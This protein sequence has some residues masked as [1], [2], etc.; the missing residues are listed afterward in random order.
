LATAMVRSSAKLP[1]E[2]SWLPQRGIASGIRQGRKD[3][4]K[5]GQEES[6]GCTVPEGQRKL[7]PTAGRRGGIATTASE[8]ARQLELFSE[9]AEVPKGNNAQADRGLP[10]SVRSDEPKSGNA[11]QEV[12]PPMTMEEVANEGN[13][14]RAFV[15]VKGNRG[16]PGPDRQS[17]EAVAAGMET[18]IPA[19][20]KSLLEGTYRAGDI[21]RVWIPKGGGGQ[22]GLGIPNVV[23]RLVQQA[24]QQVL[25]PHYEPT[26][27]ESSHGFRPGRSCHTA[28]EEARKHLEEGNEWV[29]DLD[30]EKFFD[31]VQHDRLM[32]RLGQ[33]VEDTRVLRL[34][35][36]MLRARVVMPDGVVVMTEEGVPQGG[37]LSPL[38]S[39]IVLD[40][41]DRELARRG[42][43]FTRYADDCN[44]Y[45][46]SERAGQ[47]VMASVVKFIEGRM[48]LKVNKAKSAVAR[49]EGRHF[50]GFRVRREPQTGETEVLLSERSKDRIGE[51]IRELTPRNY[52]QSLKSCIRKL[53]A[54]LLG[55]I[56]FFQIC[57]SAEERTMG[58]LDAHI[59]RRLRTIVLRHWKRKRSIAR[60]LIK[61]GV[62]AQTAWNGVYQGRRSWWALSHTPAVER[63][64]HNAYMATCGLVSLAGR[65]KEHNGLA[66][67][68]P[69]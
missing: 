29:V 11:R 31:R 57:T 33:R 35:G 56:G 51:K 21:R 17:V 14:R 9:T 16:A 66:V 13:L 41:F 34:I 36:G 23:D 12:L 3:E 54:Y 40:E 6:D 5:K 60:R 7:V 44:I 64:L 49:P 38:L 24:V 69:V 28:I 37:P 19:L 47:R 68:G 52:G 43:R 61:L 58:R 50:L 46:G 8:K 48:V 1:G 65:W 15:Q 20:S 22:R 27:H 30:L 62:R 10:P 4:M 67:T 25:S 42:H 59:R 32:S 26:F 18:L 63:G 2:T 45:V 55:W 53:N 39:N